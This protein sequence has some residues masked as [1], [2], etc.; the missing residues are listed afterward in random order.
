MVGV[1]QQGVFGWRHLPV[2]PWMNVTLGLFPVEPF[3]GERTWRVIPVPPWMSQQEWRP[4][5]LQ[6]RMSEPGASP[7]DSHS[8]MAILDLPQES[9]LG[10]STYLSEIEIYSFRLNCRKHYV[11]FN[12]RKPPYILDEQALQI[13]KAILL[14]DSFRNGCWLEREAKLNVYRGVCSACTK[15]HVRSAFTPGQI[16]RPP[17]NRVCR[18]A[19]AACP[20]VST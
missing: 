3:G 14:R 20:A 10:V 16:A 11:L 1:S 13:L 5:P 2:Q 19:T 8:C 6:P 7:S 12:E 4:L 9:V 18:G 15:S 17:D